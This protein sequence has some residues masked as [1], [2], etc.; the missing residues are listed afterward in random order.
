MS[1]NEQEPEIRL[2]KYLQSLRPASELA[3][4]MNVSRDY[5]L[6]MRHHGFRMPG[7]KA[8]IRMAH[9][10]LQSCSEFKVKERPQVSP[11]P[12][13]AFS[14]TEHEPTRKNVRRKPSSDSR[15][16]QPHTA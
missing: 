14:D 15:K 1:S 4:E 5:I 9:T 6:A 10:F 13:A 11:P 8:S 2:E 7:G 16:I 12:T 3:V